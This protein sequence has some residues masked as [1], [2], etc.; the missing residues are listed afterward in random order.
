MFKLLIDG[1]DMETIIG[2]LKKPNL[3]NEELR[4]P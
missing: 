4:F 2:L 1:S 3:I